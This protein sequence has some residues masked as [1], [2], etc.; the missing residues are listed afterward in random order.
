MAVT[1]DEKFAFVHS[2]N[3]NVP[4]M[5]G[6]QIWVD[7]SVPENCILLLDEMPRRRFVSC[8]EIGWKRKFDRL[9]PHPATQLQFPKQYDN[10]GEIYS[11]AR[12]ELDHGANTET[13]VYAS[14]KQ[15]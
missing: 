2:S 14:T 9:L 13:A 1:T 5:E 3:H 6:Y 11:L 4:R 12:I 8:P 10:Q 7:D 15:V